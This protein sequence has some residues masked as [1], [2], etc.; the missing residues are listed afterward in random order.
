MDTTTKP[1]VFVLMPFSDEF[2]DIYY[3]GIKTACNE[4]GAYSERVDEQIFTESIL[5]R[6]FNQIAKADLIV[7]DMSGRNPNVFYE[8]GYAH[9]LGKQVIL[10]TRE[11]EDIPFDMK[12]Y[13]HI[14][15]GDSIRTL[16]DEL[17]KRIHWAVTNPSGK[18]SKVDLEL[19]YY[20]QGIEL[21][22]GVLIPVYGYDLQDYQ[23]I[24][25]TIDIH[26]P[27]SRR[28]S[29]EYQIGIV[30]DWAK[31]IRGEIDQY[32]QGLRRKGY[33]KDVEYPERHDRILILPSGERMFT[34]DLPKTMRPYG[35][36]SYVVRLPIKKSADTKPFLTLR[37][38]SELSQ[39]DITTVKIDKQ[40]VDLSDPTKHFG[41]PFPTEEPSF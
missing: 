40:L 13:P 15:Y 39:K 5:E 36:W 10:L 17:Y 18:L 3:V 20:S 34:I 14:I 25:L 35:W 37:S 6:I 32:V 28:T 7:A 12:H 31:D 23:I 4:A 30:G 22:D 19:K 29:G 16:K 11:A 26:N 27:T 8:V 33:D 2:E 24:V 9:A 1:F 41:P 38:F 21:A